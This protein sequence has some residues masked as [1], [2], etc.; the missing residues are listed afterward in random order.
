MRRLRSVVAA[1]TATALVLTASPAASSAPPA[2]VLKL[3]DSGKTVTLVRNQRLRVRLK[4]C[5]GCGY[6]WQTLRAPDHRVLRRQPQRVSGGN[7][8]APC[9]GGS[10]VTIFRY[11]ARSTGTTRLRLG[12]I[13]P[14]QSIPEKTFRLRVRVR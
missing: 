4:V 1:A 14:G 6:H 9:A 3:A 7:C 10:A 5:Y 8:K 12:Y 2:K 11:V 13:P